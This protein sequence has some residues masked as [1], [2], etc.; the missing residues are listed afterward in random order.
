[1]VDAVEGDRECDPESQQLLAETGPAVSGPCGDINGFH[2]PS[3]LT[4]S[5][6]EA[7]RGFL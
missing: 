3:L 1:M 4:K 5:P 7:A 6:E 2:R